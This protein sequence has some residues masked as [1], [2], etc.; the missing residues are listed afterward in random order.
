MSIAYYVHDIRCGRGNPTQQWARVTVVATTVA[1]IP[2]TSHLSCR[3]RC[4][5][6]L[7]KSRI[8]LQP[9]H[10]PLVSLV[11]APSATLTV[12]GNVTVCANQRENPSLPSV[13]ALSTDPCLTA[14]LTLNPLSYR[15]SERQQSRTAAAITG[16]HNS[17]LGIAHAVLSH[18]SLIYTTR[19]GRCCCPPSG[20]ASSHRALTRRRCSLEQRPTVL[21]RLSQ[22]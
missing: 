5:T 16:L 1:T 3:G 8:N 13:A 7:R 15:C 20:Q 17:R 18:Q 10:T 22:K 12:N 14:T 4:S 2:R 11:A 19:T 9:S 6:F 21:A